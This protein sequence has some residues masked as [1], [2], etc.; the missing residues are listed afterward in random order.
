MSAETQA[1]TRFNEPTSEMV[2]HALRELDWDGR[3]VGYQMHS[4]AGNAPA[5]LYG[6]KD[7]VVFLTG[8]RWDRI[9]PDNHK[10]SLNW[11]H[12]ES[13]VTWLRDSVGDSELADTIATEVLPLSSYK[14]QSDRITEILAERMAQYRVALEVEGAE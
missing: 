3:F 1:L 7:A 12:M 5:N 6:L 9:G 8:T 4:S 11:V 2:E 10:A 13:F 14:A